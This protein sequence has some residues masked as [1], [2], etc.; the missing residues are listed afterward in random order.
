MYVYISKFRLASSCSHYFHIVFELGKDGEKPKVFFKFNPS[1]YEEEN[2]QNLIK[3][4]WKH[5]E[6][7]LG[8]ITSV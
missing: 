3:G 1:W 5:F 4:D 2:F 6:E 7:G 8:E